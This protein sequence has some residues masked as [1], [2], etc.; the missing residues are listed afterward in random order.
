MCKNAIAGGKIIR[1]RIRIS[2][3][4][5]SGSKGTKKEFMSGSIRT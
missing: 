2:L 5:L 3:R 1:W 4:S